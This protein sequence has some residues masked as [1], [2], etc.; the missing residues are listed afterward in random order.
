MALQPSD[1][2]ASSQ[3]FLRFNGVISVGGALATFPKANGVL[4]TGGAVGDSR[5]VRFLLADSTALTNTEK[6]FPSH[7]FDDTMPAGAAPHAATVTVLTALIKNAGELD[8]STKAWAQN[9]K[10]IVKGLSANI[11]SIDTE[12]A[13]FVIDNPTSGLGGT[14]GLPVLILPVTLSG[15][16]V[17]AITLDVLIEVP[18]SPAR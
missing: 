13:L 15:A 7:V 12:N 17:A 6:R 8:I 9:A 11:V 16:E 5:G 14:S 1:R 18:F 4:T 2:F 10:I 3:H